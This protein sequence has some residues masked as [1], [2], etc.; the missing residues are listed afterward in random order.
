ML[1]RV[2]FWGIGVT[3]GTVAIVPWAFP[4]AIGWIASTGSYPV[5]TF[6]S[7]YPESAKSLS[8]MEI[9]DLQQ[10][11]NMWI[12]HIISLCMRK[13]LGKSLLCCSVA[14]WGRK[15]FGGRS[16][17]GRCHGWQWLAMMLNFSCLAGQSEMKWTE[18]KATGILQYLLPFNLQ[19]IRTLEE[20]LFMD[21]ATF[22]TL[23][24][25]LGLME[26]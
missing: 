21:H 6:L 11:L 3:A 19:H 20:Y 4:Q 7:T 16:I 5:K 2:F 23:K 18:I 25:C 17:L 1:W 14:R 22:A 10:S 12:L 13:K 8:E 26:P 24:V 15:I 9:E